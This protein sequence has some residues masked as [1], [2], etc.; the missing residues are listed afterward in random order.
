MNA[1]SPR[2]VV[3]CYGTFDGF[4]QTQVKLLQTLA[5]YGEELI[6]GC[7]TDAHCAQMG[8]A[9]MAD[10]DTRRSMLEHCRFVDCVIPQSSDAQT[11]TDI[12]NYNVSLLVLDSQ[13]ACKIPDLSDLVQVRCLPDLAEK[14]GS[15]VTVPP[16]QKLRAVG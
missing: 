15:A 11:R 2:R 3:L 16:A 7:P 10:F 8:V 6:I 14:S 12:V 4:T 9:P 5:S 13:D 1:M